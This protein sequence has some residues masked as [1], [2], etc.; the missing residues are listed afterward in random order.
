MGTILMLFAGFGAGAIL[1]ALFAVVPLAVSG[2]IIGSILLMSGPL[3]DKIIPMLPRPLA[4]WLEGTKA[5]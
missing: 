5:G 1:T 3:V 4:A 2:L